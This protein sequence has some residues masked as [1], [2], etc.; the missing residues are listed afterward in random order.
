MPANASGRPKR[1]FDARVLRHRRRLDTAIADALP[2]L[3]RAS[4]LASPASLPDLLARDG[5]Y[6]D[7]GKERLAKVAWQ[8]YLARNPRT[9]AQLSEVR[10]ELATTLQRY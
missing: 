9:G 3:E 10:R 1:E 7:A 4:G 5:I 2:A 8:R 6:M